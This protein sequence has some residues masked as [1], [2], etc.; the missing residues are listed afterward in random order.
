LIN[1]DPVLLI[2]ESPFL[3]KLDRNILTVSNLYYEPDA[4]SILTKNDPYVLVRLNFHGSSLPPT[5]E[6]GASRRQKCPPGTGRS[7]YFILATQLEIAPK[8]ET[9]A[10]IQKAACQPPPASTT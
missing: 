1:S 3:T 4:P 7:V 5:A 6:A 10:R 2:G 9:G 8:R